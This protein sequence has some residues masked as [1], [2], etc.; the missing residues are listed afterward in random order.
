MPLADDALHFL[1]C[2]DDRSRLERA[3]RALVDRLNAACSAGQL[4]NRAGKPV[5]QQL[6]GALVRADRAIAYAIVDDIPVLV[7]DEG[8]P[9]A[10]L[11][12]R[13]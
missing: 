2:P 7:V 4:T 13:P 10:Q 11:R 12:G 1:V 3:D 5:A 9:L 6:D 8:I